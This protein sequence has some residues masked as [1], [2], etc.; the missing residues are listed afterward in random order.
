LDVDSH[1]EQAERVGAVGLANGMER[2]EDAALGWDDMRVCEYRHTGHLENKFNQL[3][4][5]CCGDL[6]AVAPFTQACT[7]EHVRTWNGD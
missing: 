1:T 6:P 7:V 5:P 4:T 3:R 2:G